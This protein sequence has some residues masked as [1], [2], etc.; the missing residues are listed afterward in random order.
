MRFRIKIPFSVRTLHNSTG[1]I[2]DASTVNSSEIA[3]FSRLSS[4]WWD[5]QGEFKLLH[6]MNPV[7]M[8]F[9]REKLTEVALEE[10][11]DDLNKDVFDGLD[12]LDVGCGGGLL[13]EASAR[14]EVCPSR[15][16][17]TCRALHG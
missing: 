2:S 17:S 5:E 6:R 12:V 11:G 7:R 10:R 4:L 16:I 14:P 8:Q 13:S 9:L 15:L 1:T 3:H